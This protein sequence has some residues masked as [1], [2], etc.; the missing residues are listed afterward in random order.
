[1]ELASLVARVQDIVGDALSDGVIALLLYHFGGKI[2]ATVNAALE[3]DLPSWIRA[4][5]PKITL[6]EVIEM[7]LKESAPVSKKDIDSKLSFL[8][9]RHNIF[10]DEF[11]LAYPFPFL[12]APSRPNNLN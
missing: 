7:T 5:P 10:N 1:M 12:F 4:L 9:A 8:E 2:E 3:N 6:N 11:S